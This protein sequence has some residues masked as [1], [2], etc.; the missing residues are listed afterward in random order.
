[1]LPSRLTSKFLPAWKLTLSPAPTFL[2]VPASVLNE[3]WSS[4]LPVLT[5]QPALLIA[6]A[7]FLT[8]ATLLSSPVLTVTLPASEFVTSSDALVMLPVTTVKLPSL[9]TVTVVPSV[10]T[11]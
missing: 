4:A 6:S 7:T 10:F 1:M 3:F 2:A 11:S 8:V 9:L 5:I